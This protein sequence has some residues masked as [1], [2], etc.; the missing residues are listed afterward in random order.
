[1][2]FPG[3]TD[4]DPCSMNT[5]IDSPPSVSVIRPQHPL[6]VSRIGPQVAGDPCQRLVCGSALISVQ[7][8][9]DYSPVAT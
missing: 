3:E 4:S 7:P 5:A 2:P 8:R 1:M 6:A 9:S